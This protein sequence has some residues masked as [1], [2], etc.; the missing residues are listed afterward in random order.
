MVTNCHEEDKPWCKECVSCCIIEGWTSENN[1]VDE[2]IKDTI[3]NAE[4]KYYYDYYYYYPLFLEWVSF[5]RFEYI[6]QIDENGFA[7]VYSAT[8][9]DGNAKYTRQGDGKWKK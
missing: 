2:F 1:D 9:I 8:W 5:D 4:M 7:K 6:K 3:Y